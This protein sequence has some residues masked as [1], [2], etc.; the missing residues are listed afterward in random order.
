MPMANRSDNGQAGVV[1]AGLCSDVIRL[2]ATLCRQT[3]PQWSFSEQA[4]FSAE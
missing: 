1:G 2:T 4:Y 3:L